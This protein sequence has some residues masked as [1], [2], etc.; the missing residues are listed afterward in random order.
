MKNPGYFRLIKDGNFVGF[1]RVITEYLPAGQ[2]KWQF[3]PIEHDDEDTQ[4]LSKPFFG[5]AD[6][7][8]LK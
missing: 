2:T 8:N 6:R 3:D 5:Q 4:K 1:K 7:D